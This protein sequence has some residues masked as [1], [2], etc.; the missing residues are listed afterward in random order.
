MGLLSSPA[1]ILPAVIRAA[2]CGTL[3]PLLGIRFC[4]GDKVFWIGP[5]VNR[6]G[7][8]I[9]CA[10]SCLKMANCWEV[11]SKGSVVI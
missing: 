3:G 6:T 11:K 5:L 1:A 8:L 9:K 2:P 4:G 7:R 10:L